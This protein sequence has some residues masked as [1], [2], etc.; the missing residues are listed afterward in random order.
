MNAGVKDSVQK[1]AMTEVQVQQLE[2]DIHTD[3]YQKDK[4]GNITSY[5]RK[6]FKRKNLELE[7][8]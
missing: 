7:D 1:P 6:F 4:H 8:H 5:E 3:E 2:L